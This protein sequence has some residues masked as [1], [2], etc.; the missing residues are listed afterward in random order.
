MADPASSRHAARVQALFDGKASGWPAKYATGGRLTGRLGQ[1]A[2][3]VS[4][5]VPAG[6]RVLDLGCGTGELTRQLAGSGLRVTGCDIAPQMLRRA[7]AAGPQPGAGWIQLAPDWRTLPLRPGCLDAVVAASVLEYVPRPGAVLGECAR[8][9]R[10]GGVVLCT[11]PDPAHPVR[12]LEWLAAPAA[13][14]PVAT[15]L[16]TGWPRFQ[17]YLA[18]LQVSR[19]RRPAGWWSSAAARA[20]LRTVGQ[21]GEAAGRAPLRLLTFARPGPGQPG[22]DPLWEVS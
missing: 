18:Y 5:H 10:P 16:A 13:R 7:A 14:V 11:V 22:T 2:A 17:H 1:L 19:Q 20:G 3:A 8:V 21:P 9:L 12:W 15:A 6:G 4:Y